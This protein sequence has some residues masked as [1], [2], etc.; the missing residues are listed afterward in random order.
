MSLRLLLSTKRTIYAEIINIIADAQSMNEN[1][2]QECARALLRECRNDF[3]FEQI[4]LGL[5]G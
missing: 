2:M 3:E 4:K 1:M 5:Q